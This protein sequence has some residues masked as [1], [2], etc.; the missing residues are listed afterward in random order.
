MVICYKLCKLPKVLGSYTIL[1]SHRYK[2]FKLVNSPI[3]DEIMD[4][5]LFVRSSFSKY[6]T[7]NKLG[8]N[9]SS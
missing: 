3:S 4:N 2:Y 5:L 8:G 1:F 6:L 7:L 9:D